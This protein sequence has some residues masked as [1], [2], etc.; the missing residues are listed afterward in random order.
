MINAE[1]RVIN[2]KLD[3]LIISISKDKLVKGK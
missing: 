1:I 3:Q 2:T